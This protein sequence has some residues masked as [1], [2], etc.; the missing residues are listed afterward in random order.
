M[1][2]KRP[3]GENLES[4]GSKQFLPRQTVAEGQKHSYV[5]E[6]EGLVIVV[7]PPEPGDSNAVPDLETQERRV[8]AA[9]TALADAEHGLELAQKGK[10][11]A[12]DKAADSGENKARAKK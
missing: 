1:V 11:A 7:D 2:D 12:E 5:G 4:N 8:E 9:K 6:A 3:S 10:K